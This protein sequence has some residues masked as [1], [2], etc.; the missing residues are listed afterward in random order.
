[1]KKMP[2]R[3]A[4]PMSKVHTLTSNPA[5]AQPKLTGPVL[6]IALKGALAG[7]L[8]P[9]WLAQQKTALGMKYS[10]SFCF[11]PARCSSLR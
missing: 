10:R 3:D 1:M 5:V 6:G 7:L 11:S 8:S 2:V 9:R 4:G